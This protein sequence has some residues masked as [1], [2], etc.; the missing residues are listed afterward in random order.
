MAMEINYHYWLRLQK[1]TWKN[2]LPWDKRA[3][4]WASQSLPSD[5]MKTWLGKIQDSEDILDKTIA[6]ATKHK[7]NNEL[8]KKGA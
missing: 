6:K 2:N 7:K 4:I 5:E 3:I 1:E 8:Q